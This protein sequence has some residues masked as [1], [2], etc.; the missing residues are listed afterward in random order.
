VT[1]DSVL[2]ANRGEIARRVMRTAH[3]M[4]L[5][6]TAVYVDA[7]AGAPFVGDAD[8]AVRIDTSYLDGAA[9]IEA[10]RLSGSGAIH[11]GYGF[12][13]ENA[14]FA[15]AVEAAGLVWVGPPPEA[16]AAM[17]DKL[18]AKELA[19]RL[20][21]PTLPHASDPDRSA[22]VGFPLLVKA[23]A[24]GGGKGMRV[25]ASAD[26]LTE[27]L[28]A[29]KR[30][31]LAGF[32]DDTVFL[33]RYLERSRHIEIQILGDRHG[34]LVHLGERECSIQRRHQ[35]LVEESPS[36]FVDDDLRTAMGEAALAIARSL[37]Y[38]SVGTV[39][40]LVDDATGAFY[41]LEVNTRLQV[42]HPVTEEVTLIDL[43]EQQIRVARDEEIDVGEIAFAGH[44][45]EVRLCAEDPTNGFL[46]ATGTLAAFE[47]GGDL[48][49]IRWESGV[50]TGSTVGV[51]FD[52]LLA[53]VIAWGEDRDEAARRLALALETLHVAGV[54]TNRDF[55]VNV[56][57]HG[58][59]LAGDTTTDF[60]D[61][62]GPSRDLELSAASLAS[63][64]AAGAMW[65]RGQN[66]AGARV[67]GSSPATWRNARLPDEFVELRHSGVTEQ[68]SYRAGRDGRVDVG[69]QVVTIHSLDDFSIDLEADGIRWR[70]RVT[71][72]GDDLFVQVPRGTVNFHV[73]PRFHVP[74]A[75]EPSGTLS[76]PMPGTVLDVRVKVGDVV[77]RGAT[78]A[79][80]E[81]MK[82]EHPIT[83]PHAGEVVDVLVEVGQQVH[84]GDILMVIDEA[85]S[86]GG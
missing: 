21:V 48:P 76:A 41:F 56:L 4:G 20:G 77:A 40:F 7:D 55:L 57:R 71:R 74:G 72:S 54:A 6:T 59:F 79:V 67:L 12:L 63:A 2:V 19:E 75:D 37:D 43:V 3:E 42:E 39:E 1:F 52:P 84:N 29:A 14:E 53:K 31:A 30:E 73:V 61:R 82:M 83:A 78:L 51:A 38:Y 34:H 81:A 65:L 27:A 28:A 49:S 80:L 24:G 11:P 18:A 47:A 44:A 23:S 35:K 58:S 62:H 36:P 69:G 9:I 25:V 85:D 33:E 45:I 50:E 15:R 5:R 10:A 17:G 13:S 22:D 86:D 60:I 66:R 26:E 32:G 70:S 46:P 8:I 16:I 64:Q 68:V